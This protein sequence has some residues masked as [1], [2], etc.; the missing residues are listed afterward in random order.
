M[1]EMSVEEFDDAVSRALDLIPAEIQVLMDNVVVLV[2]ADPPAQTPD[3]LGVYEGIP[4]TERGADWGMGTLPDAI[5]IFRNPLLAMCEDEA[6]VISEVRI[7]VLHEV[8]HFFG[9]DDARLHELGWG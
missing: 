8:G 1:V 6:Q 2:E 4:L 3:L 7:T 9:I 5:T